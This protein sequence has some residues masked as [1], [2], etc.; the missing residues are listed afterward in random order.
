[1][2]S[3]MKTLIF[4]WIAIPAELT[5]QQM[6]IYKDKNGKTMTQAQVDALDK[7]Y[8]GF[9]I[10]EFLSD[11]EPLVVQV[12]APTTNEL[13]LIKDLREE[14]TQVLKSKLLNKPLPA[15]ALEGLSGKKFN[16]KNL[17]GKRTV[18]FFFSKNDYGSLCQLSRLHQFAQNQKDKAQF[19]ALTFEDT[20]LIREFLK[21]YPLAYEIIPNSFSFV[22]Q[23]LG[24]MQTPVSMVLDR[25]GLVKF[26]TT[27]TQRHIDLVLKAELAKIK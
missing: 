20:V 16:N 7:Q 19:W 9:L 4:L 17:L 15:F 6:F 10:V 1:M 14:E 2:G 3:L 12:S 5:A 27:N 21:K 22:M 24:I 23:D 11:E 8:N 13:K 18:L 25:K 26:L